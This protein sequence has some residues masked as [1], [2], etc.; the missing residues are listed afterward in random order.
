MYIYIEIYIERGQT[1]NRYRDRD[2]VTGINKDG[3]TDRKRDIYQ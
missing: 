2:I 3:D 1:Q